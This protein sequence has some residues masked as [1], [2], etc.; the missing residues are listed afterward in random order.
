MLTLLRRAWRALRAREGNL[1]TPRRNEYKLVW[2]HVSQNRAAAAVAVAATNDEEVLRQSAENFVAI[3]AE[4]AGIAPTDVILE[5]GC[6]IGRVGKVLAPRCQ[7]WIGVD[8]SANMLRYAADNLQGITNTRFVETNG[9]DLSAIP[10][11]SVD[12]VYSTVVFMHLDD[13]ERF[14]YVREALRVLRPGGRLYVDTVN[15]EHPDGWR[16]FLESFTVDPQ[17][18]LP[19]AT[20]PSH[21]C[22]L[23]TYAARAG[24]GQVEVLGADEFWLR[25]IARKP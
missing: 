21:A 16:M 12:L 24:F 13:F 7:Q 11:Q 18:R 6:G 1:Y 17:E 20:K 8:V 19:H 9:F 5:I 25:L 22:E 2:Q 15:L 23:R 4:V 10:D 3:L 14:G